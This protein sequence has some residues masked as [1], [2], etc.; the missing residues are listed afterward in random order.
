MR[1]DPGVGFIPPF[2]CW[3]LTNVRNCSGIMAT[4][5]C[6]TIDGFTTEPVSRDDAVCPATTPRPDDSCV[7]LTIWLRWRQWRALG[8]CGCA[9]RHP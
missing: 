7:P 9:S 1:F 6:V 4:D 8:A 5:P 2:L 3:H